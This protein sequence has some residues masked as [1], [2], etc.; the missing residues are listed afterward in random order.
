[1][2]KIIVEKPYIYVHIQAIHESTTI[3]LGLFNGD[4]LR[5][6]RNMIR[7]VLTEI[8]EYLPEE[9]TAGGSAQ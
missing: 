6:F 4:E 3:D 5:I 7:K 2:L 8:E 9:K 1:M